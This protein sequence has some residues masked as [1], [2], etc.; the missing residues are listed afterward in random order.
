[1]S[2]K[3]WAIIGATVGGLLGGYIP[4]I[5]GNNDLFSVVSIIWS[6]I[7]GLAGIW[8]GYKCYEYVS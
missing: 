5:W 3:V 2:L 7:G 8:L 4:A 6:L 1:M